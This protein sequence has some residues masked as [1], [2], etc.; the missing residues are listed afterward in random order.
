MA[1]AVSKDAVMP[2]RQR[3][4]VIMHLRND[5][6]IRPQMA[7]AFMVLYLIFVVF[8]KL[9]ATSLLRLPTSL[10][11]IAESTKVVNSFFYITQGQLVLRDKFTYVKDFS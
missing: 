9:P 4:K 10:K 1:F 3:H 8:H 7:V 11:S 5:T 6:R 2:T